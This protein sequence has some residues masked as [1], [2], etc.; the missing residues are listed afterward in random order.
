MDSSWVRRFCLI[1]IARDRIV[2]GVFVPLLA[3]VLGQK[4]ENFRGS[5][6]SGVRL[7]AS[8]CEGVD[9]IRHREIPA[10][11]SQS[12]GETPST[13]SPRKRASRLGSISTARQRGRLR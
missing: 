12:S 1:K 2:S 11:K 4:V 10:R 7:G 5:L 3:I 6:V 9:L 8:I 13:I